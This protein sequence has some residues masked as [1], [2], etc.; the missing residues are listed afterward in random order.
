MLLIILFKY[1]VKFQSN[2]LKKI[3]RKKHGILLYHFFN[4]NKIT[5][6]NFF[7]KKKNKIKLNKKN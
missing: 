6:Y 1:M 5:S 2:S 3:N 4:V 7:I